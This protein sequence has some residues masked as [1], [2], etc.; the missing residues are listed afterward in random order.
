MEEL[1]CVSQLP[2]IIYIQE[3]LDGGIYYSTNNGESWTA[4][5]LSNKWIAALAIS[6][7]NIFVGV[8]GEGV[9]L[10]T[11]NGTDWIAVNNGLSNLK[12]SFLAIKENYISLEP[13]A[14]EYL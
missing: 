3:L 14:A 9:F 2:G 13:G 7:N 8:Y 6:G 12:I 1:S 10:S 4:A 11:N 5:G